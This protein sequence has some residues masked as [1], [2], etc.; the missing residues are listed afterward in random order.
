[1]K[2]NFSILTVLLAFT[3]YSNAASEAHAN[4][5]SKNDS[6]V[7]G[8]AHFKELPEGLEIEYKILGLKKDGNYGFHIHEKGDCSSKD[9]KSAGSHYQ[10]IAETGG[11][12]L[13]TPEAFAGDLPSLVSNNKGIAQGRLLIA[14]LSLEGVN[15]VKD[16]AIM[17][18]GGPDDATK[19]SAPRVACGVIKP[20]KAKK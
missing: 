14:N 9:A 19:H 8:S 2:M 7:I 20:M 1:M 5:E 15:P 12:S 13:E 11:T 16:L 3:S 4:L 10:K 18:H 6:K 17:V